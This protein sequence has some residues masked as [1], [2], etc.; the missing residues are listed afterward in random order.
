VILGL[1]G[2]DTLIGRQGNDTLRGG[3]GNDRLDGGAGND[4]LIGGVGDDTLI[5][6]Q[7]NDTLRGGSGNDRLVATAGNN[8]LEG[9]RGQDTLI[10][11]QGV[12]V[13]VIGESVGFSEI[14]RFQTRLPNRPI[15]DKIALLDNLRFRNLTLREQRGATWIGVG[16]NPIAVLL[17]V[18]PNQLSAADF[19]QSNEANAFLRAVPPASAST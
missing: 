7:G 18:K 10:G 5:G 8:L 1:G 6:G 13:F 16:N 14:R 2:N 4:L 17:N 9:G 15:S 11:G 3:K 12:D 19:I